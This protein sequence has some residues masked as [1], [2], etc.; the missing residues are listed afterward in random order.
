MSALYRGG[1]HV[2]C[3]AGNCFWS[4]AH[5]PHSLLT[6]AV[7]TGLI[8]RSLFQTLYRSAAMGAGAH[9]VCSGA[10]FLVVFFNIVEDLPFY[11]AC[12]VL[13]GLNENL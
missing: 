12:F 11:H 7:N 3:V 6:V 8:S 5:R 9:S 13:Q 4:S 2:S 1:P 10:A